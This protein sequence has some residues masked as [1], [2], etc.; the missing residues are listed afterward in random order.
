MRTSCQKG[1]M[2][3][4]LY[5]Q[6]DYRQPNRSKIVVSC[7]PVILLIRPRYNLPLNSQGSGRRETGTLN[8]NDDQKYLKLAPVI[9]GFLSG[10]S[11]VSSML[12]LSRQ[13]MFSHLNNG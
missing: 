1:V 7:K 5:T 9:Q 6:I 2:P 8:H 11:M 13:K 3:M 12:R 10:Q 4:L